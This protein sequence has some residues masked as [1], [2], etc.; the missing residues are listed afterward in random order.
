[1][2]WGKITCVA[3]V[4]HVIVILSISPITRD[5]FGV[6]RTTYSPLI[7]ARHVAIED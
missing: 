4:S 3:G 1:M 5:D 7:H 2:A 6:A